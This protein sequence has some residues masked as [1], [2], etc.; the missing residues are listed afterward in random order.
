MLA[1]W[2]KDYG[3]MVAEWGERITALQYAPS[4]RPFDSFSREDVVLLAKA[5]GQQDLYLLRGE[6]NSVC[7]LGL[8]TTTRTE[9]RFVLEMASMILACHDGVKWMDHNAPPQYDPVVIARLL[10]AICVEHLP[11]LEEKYR[12]AFR[13]FSQ[14]IAENPKEE[15]YTLRNHDTSYNHWEGSFHRCDLAIMS[16]DALM[17]HA[18]GD[19]NWAAE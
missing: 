13:D 8:A 12:N 15:W 1:R 9:R 18:T 11:R 14:Y 4:N 5:D 19:E 17:V 6:G 7:R 16:I 3:H 2:L 10:R